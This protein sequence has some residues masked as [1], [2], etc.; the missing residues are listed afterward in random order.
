MHSARL[1]HANITVQD[2]KAT[3]QELCDLFDWHIRWEGEAIGGGYTIHVG[4]TDSYL[5]VYAPPGTKRAARDS[6]YSTLGGLN[7]V[8][9]VV[10]DLDATE[11]R[12][13]S[14]GFTPRSH[15]D[16]EPGRRFYF[17]NYDGV[18]IEVISYA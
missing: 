8:G 6:S 18:E 2:P 14:A 1:E 11:K 7:H 10:D 17:E 13:A 9:I 3:A 5:A 4:N 15:A 12:I 16:Y